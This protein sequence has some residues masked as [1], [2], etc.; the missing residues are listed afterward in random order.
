MNQEIKELIDQVTDES[1]RLAIQPRDVIIKL[2]ELDPTSEEVAYLRK[3]ANKVAHTASKNR[4][5]IA[6]AIGVIGE[7]DPAALEKRFKQGWISEKI[8]DLDACIERIKQ[9]RAGGRGAAA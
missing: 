4:C 9:A 7:I 8:T 3:C 6:G 1:L 2:L 5:G